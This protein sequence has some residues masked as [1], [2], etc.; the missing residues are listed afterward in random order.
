MGGVCS[1]HRGDRT[2]VGKPEEK[3]PLGRHRRT[4]RDNIRM[5]L[6]KQDVRVCTGF[7]WLSV[8]TS[9]GLL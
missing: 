1:R 3:L 5:D 4:W 9:D 6:R 8:G 7:I 2:L